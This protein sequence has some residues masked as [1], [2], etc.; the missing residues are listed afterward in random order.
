LLPLHD[1][2]ATTDWRLTIE[3]P[4]Q[5][6]TQVI[7]Q[8][9]ITLNGIS[10][11]VAKVNGLRIELAIIPHTYAA[12]NLHTLKSGDK[13]NV[14]TDVLAKYAAAL[15]KPAD[16]GWLTPEYLLANGY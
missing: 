5:L 10:L 9:S 15:H 7:S 1:D 14:E 12:T 3:L 6:A 2:L 8:G 4:P 11:T 16:E 13:L